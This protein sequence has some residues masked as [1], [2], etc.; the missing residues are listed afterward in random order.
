MRDQDPEGRT[1]A[2]ASDDGHA[3]FYTADLKGGLQT[4]I[5]IHDDEP[6]V[7]GYQRIP[8]PTRRWLRRDV[9]GGVAPQTSRL[10]FVAPKSGTY[11]LRVT[12]QGGTTGA[13]SLYVQRMGNLATALPAYP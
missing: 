4:V 13:Y 8:D 5:E 1:V 6:A 7:L 10:H 11:Y 3:T 2:Q 9:D 12:S